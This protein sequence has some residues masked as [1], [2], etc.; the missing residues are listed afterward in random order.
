MKKQL[1][2]IAQ[3]QKQLLNTGIVLSMSQAAAV[4]EALVH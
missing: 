4:T 2:G 1:S 3:H